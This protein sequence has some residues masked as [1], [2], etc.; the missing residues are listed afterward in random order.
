[1]AK[2][3][4]DKG[5]YQGIGQHNY[6]V[7]Y[8]QV[9]SKLRDSVK[10]VFEF[11]IG[12][13]RSDISHNMGLSGKPG[14]SLRGWRE[15]F[16]SANIYAADIDKTILQPEDRIF[17]FFCDQASL[18]SIEALW[19]NP[20]LVHKNF[21]IIVEDGLHVFEAQY[22]F[23]KN[24]LHKLKDGGFYICEDVRNKDFKRWE[25]CL[26]DL[27]EDYP[28]KTFELIKID[29]PHNCWNNIIVIR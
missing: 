14:A 13:T 16:R 1:M 3:G 2:H 23:M 18:N 17:K 24:S 5:A 19:Q 27:A 22:L 9:F 29:N 26:K 7:Y 8:H 12:S 20:E 28:E 6:T 4:S 15:Y 11:G 25:S 10:N 21:D